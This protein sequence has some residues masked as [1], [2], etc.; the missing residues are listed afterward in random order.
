PHNPDADADGYSDGA[1]VAAGTNPNDPRSTPANVA[2][3]GTAIL[4]TEDVPGG[5]DTPVANNG[6][7][8]FVNDDELASHV[9]TFNGDSTDRSSYVGITWA[10]PVTNP[11]T[12][13]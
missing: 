12:R 6:L 10:S 2:R 4:G 5:I 8:T 9:D 1:E 7:I 11:I 13:L 3:T